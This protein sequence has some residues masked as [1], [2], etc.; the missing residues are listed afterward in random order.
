M[1]CGIIDEDEIKHGTRRAGIYYGI[2]NFLIRLSAVINF[3]IIGLVFSGTEWSTY[4]PNPGA[5]VIAGLQFLIGIFPCIVLLI[6]VIGL[7]FYPIKGEQLKE[8]R[9]KLTKLHEEKLKNL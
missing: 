4:T 8:N 9:I 1:S 3:T 2:I 7:Y 6:G 5:D